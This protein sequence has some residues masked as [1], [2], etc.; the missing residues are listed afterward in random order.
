MHMKRTFKSLIV[1]AVG[2]LSMNAI[3][4]Q[5]LQWAKDGN[6]YYELDQ[7]QGIVQIAPQSPSVVVMS[8]T[9]LTPA[10]QKNVLDV[11]SFSFSEDDQKI[12]LFTDT[13][14]VWRL[15]TKGNYWV[16]DKLSLI[17]I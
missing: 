15:N 14:K 16:Y 7:K 17:H 13:R 11:A 12:L 5:E 10:N 1:L 4:A 6:S 3:M 9:Q 8:K 2:V